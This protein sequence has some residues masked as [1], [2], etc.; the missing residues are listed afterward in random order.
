VTE[1]LKEECGVVELPEM[2]V[3]DGLVELVGPKEALWK[4]WNLQ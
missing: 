2:G 1:R 3:N 4:D